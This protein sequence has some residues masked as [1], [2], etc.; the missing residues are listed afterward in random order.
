MAIGPRPR[1]PPRSEAR[2]HVPESTLASARTCYSH[3]AGR[4]AVDIADALQ[5]RGLLVSREEK[6]FAVSQRGHDWFAELGIEITA[7]EM[8]EPRFAR[9]CLDWTERRHHI[10]GRLGS[11]ML[12]RFCELRWM[13]PVRDTR[14]V[15][16]T[17]EGE[18]KLW[19][20]LRVKAG[21]T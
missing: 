12:T 11:A 7:R 18:R 13:A 17:L 10:A 21:A 4:L 16:V 8:S 6:Q 19:E 1:V 2:R 3:L 15:R 5:K 9:Q 20:L 14:A